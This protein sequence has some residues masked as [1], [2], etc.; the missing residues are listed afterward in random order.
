MVGR[1][2]LGII[3]DSTAASSVWLPA[4]PIQAVCLD[5]SNPAK[6]FNEDRKPIRRELQVAEP[7][8]RAVLQKRPN[9]LEW[10]SCTT[11][12]PL[13]DHLVFVGSDRNGT[14]SDK[15]RYIDL[16]GLLIQPANRCTS[17]P[18]RERTAARSSSRRL[19]GEA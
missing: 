10:R 19:E 16:C 2:Q 8:F 13:I 5:Y 4:V 9:R 6:L 18:R 1:G 3:V 17:S 12:S 15:T 7:E 11:M 14:P